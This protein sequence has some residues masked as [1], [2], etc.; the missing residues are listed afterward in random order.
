M[1]E[2]VEDEEARK[3]ADFYELQG[4]LGTGGFSV[5]QKAVAKEDGSLAAVKTLKKHRGPS[6]SN[7]LVENEILVM[8]KIV[9]TVSPH[10]NVIHLFDVF[11]D[12]DSI[13]LV[14]E[15]CNGGEL[16]DRIV[17]QVLQA[18][19]KQVPPGTVH[20]LP[21]PAGLPRRR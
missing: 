2:V 12:D 9:E 15:L 11:E 21:S 7:A 8:N 5:V 18:I 10:P 16:F 4:V 13:H 19:G 20:Q 14:L 17:Q 3:L 6:V 1:A